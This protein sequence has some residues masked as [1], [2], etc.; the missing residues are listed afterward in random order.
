MSVANQR[1]RRSIAALATAGIAI[2]A[3]L[4][5]TSYAAT[6]PSHPAAT[7]HDS[8]SLSKADVKQ[9]VKSYVTKHVAQPIEIEGVTDSSSGG[10]PIKTIG[11]WTINL[12]CDANGVGVSV[13]G[14]GT[15]SGTNTLGQ[16]NGPA[17]SS[18]ETFG[19]GGGNS[20]GPGLQASQT[21][22]LADGT[23]GYTLTYM[24]NADKSTPVDC[25]V[26]G[27]AVRLQQPTS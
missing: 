23:H 26:L 15:V 25:V 22:V 20:A 14:P 1:S 12:S 7:S 10:G 18:F 17:G 3:V 24:A 21:L 19:G 5:G 11:P 2:V 13:T 9:I 8:K 27:Y 6:R 4:G 16:V